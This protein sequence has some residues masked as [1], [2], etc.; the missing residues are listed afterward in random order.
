MH[1]QLQVLF[2]SESLGEGWRGHQQRMERTKQQLVILFD[3]GKVISSNS[4]PRCPIHLSFRNII[5]FD[6]QKSLVQEPF[7][8]CFAKTVL[9]QMLVII[10]RR[11][12]ELTGVVVRKCPICFRKA[13]I[14]FGIS[15]RR[16]IR[17][18]RQTPLC[19]RT[20]FKRSMFNH[21]DKKKDKETR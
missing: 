12:S 5:C 1:N 13:S 4:V 16:I 18:D 21:L 10:S 15:L 9:N 3:V 6:R 11:A 7:L 14:C 20:R 2:P 8:V 19:S 17:V